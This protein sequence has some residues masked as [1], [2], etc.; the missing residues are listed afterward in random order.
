[1]IEEIS[2]VDPAVGAGVDVHN[3]VVNNTITMFGSEELQAKFLPGLATEHYGSFCLSE[4]SSGSDAFAL[5]TKAVASADGSSYTITGEKL[6]ISNAEHAGVFLVFANADFSLG[7]R[8]ITCFAVPADT[9]GVEVSQPPHRTPSS[10]P[11]SSPFPP[12]SSLVVSGAC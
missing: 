10:S 12:S 5:K 2:K 11:S 7:Y 4:A 1:V 8:G 9:P 3:T 6:W